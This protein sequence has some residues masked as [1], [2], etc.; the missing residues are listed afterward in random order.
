MIFN[1]N[2]GSWNIIFND[3]GGLSDEHSIGHEDDNSA[4]GTY[5][6]RDAISFDGSQLLCPREP[7]EFCPGTMSEIE[8]HLSPLLASVLPT[9]TWSSQYSESMLDPLYSWT[10]PRYPMSEGTCSP[11]DICPNDDFESQEPRDADLDLKLN[12]ELYG[13]HDPCIPRPNCDSPTDCNMS[14]KKLTR[15]NE[16]LAQSPSLH[17]SSSDVDIDCDSANG[18]MKLKLLDI[19]ECGIT[20]SVTALSQR[21][22][23]KR[24][25]SRSTP[26]TMSSGTYCMEPNTIGKQADQE[27]DFHRATKRRDIAVEEIEANDADADDSEYAYTAND[28]DDEDDEDEGSSS[29]KRKRQ[30]NSTQ[31]RQDKRMMKNGKVETKALVPTAMGVHIG[32]K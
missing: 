22:K 7:F 3:N 17:Q 5:N 14:Y 2:F 31:Q 6:V 9:P 15:H 11:T 23:R 19:T 29:R 16:P 30:R 24:P 20:P 4:Q 21:R 1:S 25:S 27:H 13:Y 28:N 12:D 10:R 8:K 32:Q 26:A 18:I